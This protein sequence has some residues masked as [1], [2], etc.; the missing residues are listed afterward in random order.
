VAG[1]DALPGPI[2]SGHVVTRGA[3]PSGAVGTSNVRLTACLS[4][5]PLA[6]HAHPV[7]CAAS[8]PRWGL[9]S[10]ARSTIDVGA[11]ASFEGSQ[12]S[13]DSVL[14]VV[15]STRV[16][17]PTHAAWLGGSC[18]AWRS[19]GPMPRPVSRTAC[20]VPPSDE[21]CVSRRDRLQRVRRARGTRAP[22][23]HRARA[24]ARESAL[25]LHAAVRGGSS[26][27]MEG[28]AR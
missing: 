19:V 11:A 13:R 20:V 14:P 4:P 5:L 22:L 9:A 1:A 15:S 27:F 17:V 24:I 25:H 16:A 28:N 21:P 7:P 12:L 10:C 18:I 8:T 2:Q 26:S 23:A 6:L 3:G